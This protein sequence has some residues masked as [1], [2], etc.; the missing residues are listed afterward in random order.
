MTSTR[1]DPPPCR[2]AALYL[3]PVKALRGVALQ[4]SVLGPRGLAGDRAWMLISGDGRFVSQRE[5]PR[6][7]LLSAR[8]EQ[9]TLCIDAAGLATLRVPLAAGAGECRAARVWADDCEVLDAGDE[10]A[11]WL[12]AALESRP[13]RLVRMRPD[14]RR[15]LARAAL[16]GAD[17]TTAFADAAPFLVVNRP[18]L[19]ALNAELLRNGGNAVQIERFRPN[20]VLEGL[21][22]FAEH[23]VAVLRGAQGSFRL[24]YPCERCAVITVDPARGARDEAGRRAFAALA[25]LNPLPGT[26]K[27]VFG[28]NATWSGDDG[29]TLRIG[30][31]FEVLKAPTRVTGDPA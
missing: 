3:Y 13:C 9:D 26:A 10:A 8:Y 28:M 18:S 14:F 7:A 25:T 31:T 6:L 23:A 11:R 1:Q 24:C 15:R 27:P 16:L 17:T 12:G 29:A 20:V 4:Q 30:D 5:L 2:V 21:S 22:P 19:D